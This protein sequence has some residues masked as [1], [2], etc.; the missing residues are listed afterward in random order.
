VPIGQASNTEPLVSYRPSFGPSDRP[1]LEVR[2]RSDAYWLNKAWEDVFVPNLADAAA[3][4][5]AIV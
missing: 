3:E 5:I 4:V 1:R 2:L